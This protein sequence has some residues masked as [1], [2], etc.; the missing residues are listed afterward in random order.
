MKKGQKV[1]LV[2]VDQLEGAFNPNN[3]EIGHTVIGRC[4]N[5]L[6]IGC[7]LIIDHDISKVFYTSKVEEIIS[8]TRFRTT[9]SI[10]EITI[11][12]DETKD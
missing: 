2:K 5:D 8:E 4:L 10:Y 9:N 7:S 12:Q 3:I 6:E 1:K 11:E